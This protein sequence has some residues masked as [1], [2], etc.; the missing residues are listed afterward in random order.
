MLL[1]TAV[2][3]CREKSPI[4]AVRH[5]IATEDGFDRT[6][7]DEM[8]ALGWSGIAIPE[9][10]GGSDLSLAEVATIAEPMGC[11]LLATPFVSTQIFTQGVLAGGTAAA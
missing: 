5:Q 8:V 10:F 9:R 7:W 1:E 3:F 4:R 11:H 6:L 2:T